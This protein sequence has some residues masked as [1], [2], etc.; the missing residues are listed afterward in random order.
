MTRPPSRWFWSWQVMAGRPW[1]VKLWIGLALGL[2]LF[3]MLRLRSQ[4]HQAK[5]VFRRDC[6]SRA[7]EDDA[8]EDLL[9]RNHT[10]CFRMS[11]TPGGKGGG[12][13]VL[14]KA[15]YLECVRISPEAWSAKRRQLLRD[16]ER[17]RARDRAL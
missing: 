14:D 17:R 10:R 13:D 16:E 15:R 3:L 1:L 12:P 8:C 5:Q 4:E 11:F 2:L 9:D 7:T 6:S